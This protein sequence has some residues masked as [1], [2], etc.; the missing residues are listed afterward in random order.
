ML[1][2]STLNSIRSVRYSDFLNIF[3]IIF[4]LVKLYQKI[5]F[6]ILKV[7]VSHMG[8]TKTRYVLVQQVLKMIFVSGN[9]NDNAL[10]LEAIASP[11]NQSCLSLRASAH[12][13]ATKKG[14]IKSNSNTF[15]ID[16]TVQQM[17]AKIVA[18]E[19][20]ANE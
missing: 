1:S 2:F 8:Q 14:A 19:H 10:F 3:T 13:R 4:K 16:A 6:A 11:F 17:W 18:S 15:K 7:S 20:N 12:G 9:S 5:N